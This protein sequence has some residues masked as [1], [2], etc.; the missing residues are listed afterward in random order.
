MSNA[1][2][3]PVVVS[4][5]VPGIPGAM[6]TRILSPDEVAKQTE[7]T[8]QAQAAIEA[9]RKE[10]ALRFGDT[11]KIHYEPH[12]PI[13]KISAPDDFNYRL[14]AGQVVGGVQVKTDLRNIGGMADSIR[15][16]GGITT[17]LVVSKRADGEF[18]LCQ[19]YRRLN[20]AKLIRNMEPH[21]PLSERL[22]TL[23]C[24]I[25]E[26]LTPEQ[27]RLLV[28]DQTSKFYTATEVFQIFAEQVDG[29]FGWEQI[30]RRMYPQIGIVTKSLDKVQKIDSIQDEAQKRNEL[31]SWLTTFVQQFWWNG[32]KAGPVT[33]NLILQTYMWQDGHTNV[34]PR[35]I[36]DSVR[37]RG[38]QTEIRKDIKEG[39]WNKEAG[40][41]PRFEAKLKEYEE[42]DKKKYDKPDPGAPETPQERL[43][44]L[45]DVKGLIDDARKA[46]KAPDG[47]VERIFKIVLKDGG[48][49]AALRMAHNFD[50]CASVYKLHKD[51]VK[52]ELA[53]VFNLIFDGGEGA[54]EQFGA[55]LTDNYAVATEGETVPESEPTS[56]GET[57]FE[58]Q[59]TLETV[60]TEPGAGTDAPKTPEGKPQRRKHK[61]K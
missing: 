30:A 2:G 15:A 33:R 16:L 28:N 6:R 61:G 43:K 12:L 1:N 26:G 31:V 51:F 27:E 10:E 52:P 9:L 50:R 46:R 25:Y 58:E 44:K 48:D 53:A 49:P 17:P 24:V 54:E 22:G 60:T 4:E 35:V 11:V 19:G 42:A 3:G 36:M 55:F 13:D 38:L 37:M 40:T 21:S 5:P 8:I 7:A 47:L 29:G 39:H 41:G 57:E 56:E 14:K 34:R 18:R 59:P 32:I 23:P 45:S 20:G